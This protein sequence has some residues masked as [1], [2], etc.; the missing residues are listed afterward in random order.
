MVADSVSPVIP[1]SNLIPVERKRRRV[2]YC[3]PSFRI[4]FRRRQLRKVEAE[5]KRKVVEVIECQ[6]EIITKV[7]EF[8]QKEPSEWHLPSDWAID[9]KELPKV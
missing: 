2:R 9:I 4:F 7:K 8:E 3:F 6:N 1:V 5:S